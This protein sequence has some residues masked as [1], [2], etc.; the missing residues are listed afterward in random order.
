[1][2][3]DPRNLLWIVPL[4]VLLALPLWKPLAADF[5]SPARK[6]TGASV[7]SRTS[8]SVLT[9]TA[10]ENVQ[11]EQSKDGA[12]EWFLTASRLYSKENNSAMELE[13]VEALFYA[14]PGNKEETKISSRK[15]RYNTNS[16]QLTLQGS[17]VVKN[18]Q[19]YEMLT[20]SLEYL[21]AEKKIRTTSPVRIT[22][23]NIEV[24]GKRLLYDTETGN[25]SI[26][27]KVVCRIW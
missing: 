2:M 23:K 20:D 25:Y 10:M 22:G 4:A 24:S 15:A 14:T 11:F 18:Q 5:L 1:M 16:R 13:D 17:V 8:L 19:G 6:R 27:G 12:R 7:P 3:K 26:V 21:S 9:G